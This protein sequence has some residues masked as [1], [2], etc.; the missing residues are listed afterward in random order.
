MFCLFCCLLNN[1]KYL[2]DFVP[3]ITPLW[4]FFF[5]RHQTALMSVT[6]ISIAF[7]NN[8]FYLHLLLFNFIGF[9]SMVIFLVLRCHDGGTRV[10]NFFSKNLESFSR[11]ILFGGKSWRVFQK[12][13]AQSY[14]FL[15]ILKF[16]ESFIHNFHF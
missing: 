7:P 11:S 10:H 1:W 5:Y 15:L 8:Y 3:K 4:S 16:P 12:R 6:F 14:S 13:S 2:T 9:I